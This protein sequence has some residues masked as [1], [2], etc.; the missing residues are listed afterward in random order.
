LARHDTP[1][2]GPF[3]IFSMLHCMMTKRL[4]EAMIALQNPS[5]EDRQET[6]EARIV[7][8]SGFFLLWTY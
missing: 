5:P 7:S 2:G 3:F 6:G 8:M 1:P 4:K